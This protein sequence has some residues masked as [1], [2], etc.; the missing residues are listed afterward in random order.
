VVTSPA[1]R[2]RFEIPLRPRAGLPAT[3]V[4]G[5]RTLVL[6]IV[7]VTPDSFSDGG[8][9]AAPEAAVRH[10]LRLVEEG[11]DLLDVGGESTRPGADEVPA[12]E[13]EH[14]V[15]PVIEALAA[16]APHVPVSVDTRSAAVARAAVAAGA[17]IVND[18]SGLAHDP[19]MARAVASLGVP[20]IVMHMRGTPADMRTR[21]EYGD[22]VADVLAE[23]RAR[24]DAAR[25]AG[26]R[27][28]LAD[29]G[30]GFAK[31][32]EQSAALLA[33]T[34][35][36]AALGVP[37]VVGASRKSFLATAVRG[38]AD[39]PV[40]ETRRAASVAAAALAAWLGAHVVRVHDVAE[41]ADAVRV[42]DLL[43]SRSGVANS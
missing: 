1:P 16:R 20:A 36:L 14:R 25:A 13:Q 38:A 27:D 32:A 43:R 33:A 28:L 29:P 6:G 34:P 3:L 39:R 22:V 10:A 18:V 19:E 23:L 2:S 41:T 5:E 7:N 12:D 24:L 40:A 9:H 4:L 30:I 37:V 15:L 11:A 26:C 17:S 31:T 21:T 42:A 8:R 35:R